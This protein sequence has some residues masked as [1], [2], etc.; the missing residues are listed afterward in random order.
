MKTTSKIKTLST[1]LLAS[2]ISIFAFTK[3]SA[4][5]PPIFEGPHS[6]C[7]YLANPNPTY[8]ITN[9]N[10]AGS[11]QAFGIANGV[12]TNNFTINGFGQFQSG[13][14]GTPTQAM[15]IVR[16]TAPCIGADT[17]NLVIHLMLKL[18]YLML[19]VNLFF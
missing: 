16:I 10:P 9:F 12:T 11:Y 18:N 4:Q 8:T 19:V 15:I 5:C 17:I 2:A 14:T 3:S 13:F 6:M 1:F 7:S